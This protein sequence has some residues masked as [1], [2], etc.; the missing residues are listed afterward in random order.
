M[1]DGTKLYME[2]ICHRPQITAF[3]LEDPDGD[4]T[5]SGSFEIKGWLNG[6]NSCQG[7]KKSQNIRLTLKDGTQYTWSYPSM[8][9]YNITVGQ[10]YQLYMDKIE[11]K[12]LTNDL[13][14]S[15][16]YNPHSDNTYSGMVKRGLSFMS[17]KKEKKDEGAKPKRGDDIIIEIY[18]LIQGM[19]KGKNT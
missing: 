14:A 3:M 1:S 8:F 11:L 6:V 10:Q 15:I 5:L 16:H 17:K 18:K 7:T 4:Y 2:Q 12:D 19:D 9:I 13:V